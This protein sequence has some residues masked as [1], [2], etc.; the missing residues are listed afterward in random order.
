MF[1]L[2]HSSVEKIV[3]TQL[4]MRDEVS[5]VCKRNKENPSPELVKVKIGLLARTS[6][7]DSHSL[8]Y[9]I[10]LSL[11]FSFSRHIDTLPA[12]RDFL[13]GLLSEYLSRSN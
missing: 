6:G 11:S 7:R 10:F 12:K 4:S 5:G 9:I 2:F 3:K 1:T 8:Y 13:C